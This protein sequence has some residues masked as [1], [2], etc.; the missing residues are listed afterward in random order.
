MNQYGPRVSPPGKTFLSDVLHL[1]VLLVLLIVLL[2]ILTKFKLVHPSMVPGW[3]PVYCQ[4][5]EQKHSQIAIVTTRSGNGNADELFASIRNERPDLRV[6]LLSAK[7]LSHELLKRYEVVILEQTRDVSFKSVDSI[8]EYLSQGGTLI[9]TGD[10]LSNQVPDN[11]DIAEAKRKNETMKDYKNKT[12][13]QY[14]SYY[15]HFL[16]RTQE[17]GFGSFGNEFIGSYVSTTQS[18]SPVIRLIIDDHLLVTG[19]LKELPLEKGA[20][21]TQINPLNGNAL[22]ASIK[23]GEEEYPA[24]LEQ[25][26]V[27]KIIYIA[28]PLTS[29]ESKSF[30]QNLFDYLVTC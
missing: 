21:V 14:E 15:D 8:K 12:G 2:V 10:S 23:V 3:Q 19:L 29:I 9:W 20:S 30:R 1:L 11:Q 18:A 13:G 17:D 7:D 26:Y 25:K 27:S 22:I 16:E 5:V 24:I 4:F 28:V 6:T